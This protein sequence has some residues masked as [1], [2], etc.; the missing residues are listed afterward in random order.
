MLALK[1]M[2]IVSAVLPYVQI[3]LSALLVAAILLQQTGAGVG[4]AFGGSDMSAGFHTR[5]G[6]ER[7][8]F[9]ATIVLGV[10]FAASSFLA[11]IIR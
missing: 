4:G 1:V 3:A 10:L 7:T 6:L 11:L 2:A 9:I 8:L 5:R